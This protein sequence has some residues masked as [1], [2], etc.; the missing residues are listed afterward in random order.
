MGL[1]NKLKKKAYYWLR[2]FD[3][4]ACES[5]WN[6]PSTPR[7]FETGGSSIT[8]Y[9]ARGGIVLEHVVYDS[10]TDCHKPT[11]YVVP[12]DKNLGEAISEII[13]MGQLG[14]G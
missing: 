12:E 3:D 14:N 11:L 10:K 4:D 13:T 5:S 1:I 2:D 7:L 6:E 9:P 8:Y